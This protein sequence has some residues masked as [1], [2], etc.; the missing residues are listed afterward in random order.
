MRLVQPLADAHAV[1]VAP[2]GVL[3]GAV[4][5]DA[6]RLRQVLVNLLSN[7]VKYNRADGWV[8]VDCAALDDA[9]VRLS[10]TDSGIGIAADQLDRLFTPFERLGAEAGA[11][12]G[13]GVGLALSRR[14]VELMGGRLGVQSRPGDGSTFW[15]DLPAAHPASVSATGATAARAASVP[16]HV[17]YIEDNPVNVQVVQAMLAR[18]GVRRV[19]AAPDGPSGLERAREERPQL[20]LLDIQLP[21]MDGYAVLEA[22]KADPVTCDIPVIALSADAMPDE[23][24]RG[25]ARGLHLYLT[26]PVEMSELMTALERIGSP[27]AAAGGM[28]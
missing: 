13:T 17:L 19:D 23:I 8:R 3:H 1:Q 12:E 24:E 26:K 22:L 15:V 9:W 5:A 10:V 11:V 6:T 2:G 21:G 20:I 28:A 27:A 4:R 14:L 18:L 7:A 25:L 16:Q